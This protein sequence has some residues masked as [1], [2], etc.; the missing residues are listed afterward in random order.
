[1]HSI[2]AGF[3]CVSRAARA[4]SRRLIGKRE[5]SGNC[6]THGVPFILLH[7]YQKRSDYMDHIVVRLCQKSTDYMDHIVVRLYQKSTDYM[8]H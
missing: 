7:I 8:D 2:A 5:T 4:V 6:Y 3:V 1:V